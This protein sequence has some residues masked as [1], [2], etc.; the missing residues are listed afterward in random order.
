MNGPRLSLREWCDSSPAAQSRRGWGAS[1]LLSFE[2]SFCMEP[3]HALKTAS[4]CTKNRILLPSVGGGGGGY[5]PALQGTSRAGPGEQNDRYL[6]SDLRMK[7]GIHQGFQMEG[8][9][10]C[11][12]RGPCLTRS[13][14][15][16]TPG[17]CRCSPGCW[18]C[19]ERGS[20]MEKGG[21]EAGAEGTSEAGW[22]QRGQEAEEEKR[23]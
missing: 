12:R 17:C 8:R 16:V 3:L 6:I 21:G 5:E 15:Q 7:A 10:G 14:P 18:A 4:L 2:S 13:S 9:G 19:E 20:R 1:T 11:T 22:E 23:Q